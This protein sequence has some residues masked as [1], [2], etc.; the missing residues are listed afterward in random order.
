MTHALNGAKL[1]RLA[2]VQA[3]TRSPL[4]REHMAGKTIDA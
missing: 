2:G 4:H 3:N 1:S